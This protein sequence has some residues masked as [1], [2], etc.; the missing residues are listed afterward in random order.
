MVFNHS[1]VV[2]AK[3]S[4]GQKDT[5]I[6]CFVLDDGNVLVQ[7]FTDVGAY[8]SCDFALNGTR[9]TMKS[10][11]VNAVTGTV[12]DIELDLVIGYLESEYEQE[13]AWYTPALKLANGRDN[14]V[15]AYNVA[16][17]SV[18]AYASICVM[19]NTG[20]IVY[21]VKNDTFGVDFQHGIQYIGREM[22]IATMNTNG[23]SW[24]AI[25]DID[26]NFIS[27]YNSDVASITDKYIVSNTAI[28]AYDMGLVYDFAADGYSSAMVMGNQVYLVK[29]N[30]VSGNIEVY[31][32]V[33]LGQAE[34][35]SADV[36][37]EFCYADN[38][39]FILYNEDADVYTVYNAAGEELI[40]SHV[41]LE[42][43]DAGNCITLIRTYF[44]GERIVYVLK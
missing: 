39:F 3:Y 10:M 18:S 35:F 16:N 14:L 22:Y 25:F 15:V 21:T 29:T 33:G 31:R 2:S 42:P 40:V 37:S 9:Y 32:Y 1:G 6:K 34:L 26:G 13:C 12:T 7:E 5:Y 19:D 8:N 23:Y 11:I 24:D 43:Q 38:D 20:K 4:V 30:Y 44:E 17:G 36:E 41:Y 28:Y 27:A